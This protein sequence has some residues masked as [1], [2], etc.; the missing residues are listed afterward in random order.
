MLAAPEIF[1]KRGELAHRSQLSKDL[2][3]IKEKL[4]ES[5]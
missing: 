3:E 1:S 5:M 4:L 2:R